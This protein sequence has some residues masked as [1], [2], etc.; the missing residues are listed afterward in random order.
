MER[1]TWKDITKGGYEMNWLE[2]WAKTETIITWI[3]LGLLALCGIVFVSM[4][5]Y[6]FIKGLVRRKRK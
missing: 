2:Q 5:A 1:K 6:Q 3:A 4:L